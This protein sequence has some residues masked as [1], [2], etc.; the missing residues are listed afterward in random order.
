MKKIIGFGMV[1]LMLS[2]FLASIILAGFMTQ[3]QS[4]RMQVSAVSSDTLQSLE[5]QYVVEL[6]RASIREA[7]FTPCVALSKLKIHDSR[8]GHVQNSA[9]FIKPSENSLSIQR[10]SPSFDIV[11]SIQPP[12]TI[13]ATPSHRFSTKRAIIIAD[14]RHAEIH[15]LDSF[16]RSGDMQRLILKKPLT[17]HYKSPMYVGEWVSEHFS[18]LSNDG[19]YVDYGRARPE[20]VSKLIKSMHVRL[21]SEVIHPLLD[22]DFQLEK[23]HVKSF[24]SRSRT[25]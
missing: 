6:M 2:L 9:L 8:L 23:G 14:C 21:H 3:V 4:A 19:L 13:V 16:V 25:C 7:G 12:K 1:E 20:Q 17:Y 22:I 18:V 5:L 15:E 24:S 10:M 11:L